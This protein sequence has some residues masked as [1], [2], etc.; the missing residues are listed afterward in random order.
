MV[1]T[2]RCDRVGVAVSIYARWFGGCD[3]GACPKE[4]NDKKE[5]QK[6]VSVICFHAQVATACACV[7]PVWCECHLLSRAGCNSM[8]LRDSS[9][10]ISKN[11][12]QR[13][14]RASLAGILILHVN[15]LLL[16]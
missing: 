9:C 7:T 16:L 13:A 15:K 14:L 6:R 3:S 10:D 1:Q 5:P 8:R 4:E 2:Y 12:V 11:N